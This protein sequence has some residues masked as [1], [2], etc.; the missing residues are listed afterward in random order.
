M[1]FFLEE[2]IL[3]VGYLFHQVRNNLGNI[4]NLIAE[5][6]VMKLTLSEISCLNDL[7]HVLVKSPEL[8]MWF[9]NHFRA[10]FFNKNRIFDI[11]HDGPLRDFG[12]TLADFIWEPLYFEGTLKFRTV[13][14][15]LD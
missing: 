8:P 9:S 13:P 5:S 15:F 11:F 4:P 10:V 14:S 2:D 1:L 12:S 7:S 6:L 3:K